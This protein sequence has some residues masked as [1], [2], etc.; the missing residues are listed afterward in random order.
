MISPDL[1]KPLE[2][3]TADE[4]PLLRTEIPGPRSRA[5]HEREA[6]YSSPGLSAI[7][8]LSGLAMDE[9]RGALV[10]DVDGNV[11]ID[12]SSGTVVTVTGHAHPAVVK[13]LQEALEHFIHIYDY[14]S[15][16]RAAFFE[17]LAGQMPEQLRMFQMYTGGAETVEAAL[18]LARSATGRHEFIS[19]YRAFHGKTLGA[20]SLMGGMFKK[21]L[22][23][24]ASGFHQ[25]PNA[26]CYRC[27][28]QLEYPSCGVACADFIENVYQQETSGDVAAVVVEPIQGAGGVI[29]PPPEFLTKIAAFCKRN[30]I[31]LYVD[32]ILTSAGRTG[33]MWA[34]EHYGVQPDIMTLG[35]GVGSG[36]PLGIVA[37]RDDL[38][39]V[40]PWAQYNGASTTFGGSPLSAVAGL[41]TLKAIVEEGM[42]EN[43]ARVGAHMKRR[44]KAIQE[45]HETIGDVRGEGM[46][47][48]VE[49]V[50]DRR[51]KEPISAAEAEQLYLEVV[52]RGVLVSNAGQTLRITPPLVLSEEL[53]DRGLDLFEQ[54]VSAFEAGL[55]RSG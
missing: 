42:V 24:L 55:R 54:A 30:G 38:M 43:A 49:F 37:S 21:G 41:L 31:L 13:G 47:M 44:L 15:E 27:P 25:T 6:P 11:F 39:K 2:M 16:A 10:R 23:P 35:K 1:Q 45:R 29:V 4:V 46:L 20:L 19:L 5:V 36:F 14:A 18:R 32:E 33:K 28:L 17:Y 53:A 7:A 3:L 48:G 22:G 40:W 51:T 34:I 26:Y 12:F 9:G 52:R 8:V 50:R